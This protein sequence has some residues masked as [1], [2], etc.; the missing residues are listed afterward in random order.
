MSSVNISNS[1]R[2]DESYY[3]EMKVVRPED[4]FLTGKYYHDIKDYEKA[5]CWYESNPLRGQAA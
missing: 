4:Q 2:S 3:D 1:L 5:L